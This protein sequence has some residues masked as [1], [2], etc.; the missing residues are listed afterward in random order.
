MIKYFSLMMIFC[1]LS[2][3]L[4]RRKITNGL[5]RSGIIKGSYCLGARGIAVERKC[6]VVWNCTSLRY[7]LKTMASLAEGPRGQTLSWP[8]S[9]GHGTVSLGT[10]WALVCAGPLKVISFYPW[11]PPSHRQH[12]DM[13]T[14]YHL[15]LC[16][17]LQCILFC[18]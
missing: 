8:L 2:N 11:F 9:L 15:D 4:N 14:M 5:N 1:S 18:V 12:S 13:Y 10:W 17:F 16:V 3:L 7:N 6:V